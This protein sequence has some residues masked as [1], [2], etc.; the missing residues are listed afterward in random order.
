MIGTIA[1]TAAIG[2]TAAPVAAAV[3]A[4]EAATGAGVRGGIETAEFVRWTD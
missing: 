3:V 2:K 4:A 1:A